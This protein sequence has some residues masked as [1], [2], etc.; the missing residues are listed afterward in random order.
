MARS[1]DT[2]FRGVNGFGPIGAGTAHVRLHS[3]NYLPIAGY[4]HRRA[5][6]SRIFQMHHLA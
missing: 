3:G 4:L 2:G 6:L 1:G 5:E